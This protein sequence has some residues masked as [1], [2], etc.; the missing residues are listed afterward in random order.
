MNKKKK[1]RDRKKKL[2]KKKSFK[3]EKFYVIFRLQQIERNLSKL[4][5]PHDYCL[6]LRKKFTEWKQ[7][8]KNRNEKLADEISAENQK[9]R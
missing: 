2:G 6:S 1:I 8:E 3:N 9:N 5:F 7:S 4:H